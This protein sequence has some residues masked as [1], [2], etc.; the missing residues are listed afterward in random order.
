MGDSASIIRETC[1][2]DDLFVP[3]SRYIIK[4][5][6]DSRIRDWIVLGVLNGLVVAL[7]HLIFSLYI[8]LGPLAF[9]MQFFHQSAENLLIASVYL[10]MP[11]TAPRQMPFTLNA[12]VWSVMGMMQGWWPVIPVAVP[13]GII[14]DLIVRVPCFK[15]RKM[16]LLLSYSF[17]TTMLSI[18]SFWP[19]MFMTQSS[20][21]QRMTAMD[22]GI[23]SYIDEFT[24]PFFISIMAASFISALFGGYMALR[25]ISR[26][27]ASD[28]TGSWK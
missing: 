1:T 12:V 17:Y 23:G 8:F 14:A 28:G 2:P 20:M 3:A 5:G 26:H 4:S 16:K 7:S 6:A 24:M 25:F 10:L 19:F 11:M 22:P 27:F 13:A 21:I 18:A 9:F 15:N